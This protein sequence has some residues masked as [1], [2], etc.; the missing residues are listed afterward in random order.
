[1]GC[2]STWYRNS[3]LKQEVCHERRFIVLGY[4]HSCVCR[5]VRTVSSKL[6][7]YVPE[8]TN[9][10]TF[11]LWIRHRSATASSNGWMT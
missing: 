5:W 9:S 2:M 4:I 6:R 11:H 10:G 7:G 8:L 3:N 1:M